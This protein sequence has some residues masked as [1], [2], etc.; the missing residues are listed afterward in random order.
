MPS[1]TIPVHSQHINIFSS[2]L[3][4]LLPLA[5]NAAAAA[6]NHAVSSKEHSDSHHINFFN[7]SLALLPHLPGLLLLLLCF[8]HIFLRQQLVLHVL[9]RCTWGVPSRVSCSAAAA[10]RQRPLRTAVLQY[11]CSAPCSAAAGAAVAASK[12]LRPAKCLTP[13]GAAA[14]AASLL[15][16][17]FC[18]ACCTCGCSCS[19]NWL[20]ESQ[21][22]RACQYHCSAPFGG[23]AAAAAVEAA[24]LLRFPSHLPCRT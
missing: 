1:C 19:C 6:A 10:A 11:H 21:L 5:A 17:P 22:R 13:S 12:H 3:A 14:A 18:L 2:S 23:A 4:L 20:L 8:Q 24:C 15:R 16:F 9:Y 7:R